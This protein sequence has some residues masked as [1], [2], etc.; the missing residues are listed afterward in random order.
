MK[1]IVLATAAT[2]AIAAPAFAQ[3]QLEAA[4]GAEAGQFTIAELALLN[5]AKGTDDSNDVGIA[6]DG[7]DTVRFS[8]SEAQVR[9]FGEDRPI[10][11]GTSGR[12]D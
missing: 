5:H 7:G 1:R 10:D 9:P 3:S 4:V 2:L 6:F 8:S 12:D 11:R